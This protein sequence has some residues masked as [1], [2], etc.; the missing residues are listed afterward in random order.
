[1]SA[2]LGVVDRGWCRRP[3]LEARLRRLLADA[4]RDLNAAEATLWTFADDDTLAAALNHGPD[5]DVVEAQRV[6]VGESVVGFVATHGSGMIVGPGEWQNPTVM[7][8]TGT[9]VAAMVAVSVSLGGDVVGVLSVI[10]P[11]G[12]PRFGAEDLDAAMWHAFLTGAVMAR[13]MTESLP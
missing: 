5:A 8:A 13:A 10:N 2:P 9:P 1:M 4:A 12:R 6:P 7:Q 11:A 3:P